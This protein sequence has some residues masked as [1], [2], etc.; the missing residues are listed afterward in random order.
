[1]LRDIRKN[2]I[3]NRRTFIVGGA[4]SAL[5]FA[6]VTR[7]SYLQLLKHD[8]YSTQSDSNS[9]KPI[10][11]VAPRGVVLDRN[12]AVI[13]SNENHYRLLLYLDK[14]KGATDI[15]DK[16]AEI[17]SLNEEEKN[18]MIARVKNSRRKSMISLI[19]KL[20]WSDLARIETNS[21]RLPGISIESGILRRYLFPYET[22]HFL[23]YASLPADKEIDEN[24]QNLFMH[25]D[26][27]IGKSGLERS[28][29][30][31][32][33]GKYGAKYVEVNVFGTPLR[34]LSTKDYTEG[35]RLHVTIDIRL[36]QA[37]TE[38]IKDVVASVVMLDVKT[39]EILTCASS[40][41][42]DPN[43][44]AEGIQQQYW[45]ELNNDP[46]KPLNNKAISAIYPP[47]STFKL[48][49]ALAALES[50]VNP[51]H[52]VTCNGYY[53]SGRRVFHCWKDGGHGSLDMM[54]G[55]TQSCNVM[56]FTLA[57]QIGIEKISEMARRFG[58]GEKFDISLYGSRAGNVPS[59]EWKRQV[60]HQPWVGGDTLNTAIGQGFVLATP[61]Q[62]A[63]ITARLANGGV[64][65]KPYLVRNHNIYN[66][67]DDL[68]NDTLVKNPEHLN[69]VLE[70]MRRVVN[71]PK[72]TSYAK[73]IIEPG[74]EMAGKT[75]TS[76][77]ISKR[78]KEMSHAE[79]AASANHG[80]FVGFAPVANP[81]YAISVVVEHGKSGSGSA[82]PIAHDLLLA[83]QTIEQ[84]PMDNS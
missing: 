46:R 53:Q 12:G 83:A 57:N 13:A 15:I 54:E 8:E 56:F 9:I 6:L 79:I 22:A 31:A 50:G 11:A 70:G 80:I 69:F 23:G 82:A 49:V 16:V 65:I 32:L 45:K 61:L 78:E 30:E 68:K 25:P 62:M 72:G 48:M 51:K 35:S 10:I 44:F 20:D 67:F 74:L 40:P 59:D 24:E 33:R 28:F 21:Y 71:D 27:R 75:G 76:Q 84:K 4:Q 37:A 60:F 63:L 7:L 58:Y 41:S 18:N 34:T 55:I 19:D 2:K 77:V 3:F 39:G 5:T 43:S 38:R 29:D 36:Q 47:G 26:F 64:P 42:F 1:M 66:Q 17:L 14:K 52:R 73:R 81:K